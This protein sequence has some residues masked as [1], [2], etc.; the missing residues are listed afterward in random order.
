MVIGQLPGQLHEII[1]NFESV[2]SVTKKGRQTG[3]DSESASPL[4]ECPAGRNVLVRQE[5]QDAEEQ[6]G[7]A[8]EEAGDPPIAVRVEEMVE[9]FIGILDEGCNPGRKFALV[10]LK[11]DLFESHVRHFG[12]CSGAC[13]P[14]LQIPRLLRGMS[15]HPDP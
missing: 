3:P 9:P 13:R 7:I 5:A 8:G 4:A 6:D 11:G 14:G 12:A 15:E 1:L 2:G 10:Q